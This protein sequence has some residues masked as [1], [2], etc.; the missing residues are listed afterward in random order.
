MPQLTIYVDRDL[1]AATRKH[2]VKISETCQAALRRK[3]RIAERRAYTA[4]GGRTAT[5]DAQSG[6][7]GPSSSSA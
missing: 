5:S 3:V 2:G 1:A 4:L 7:T 6:R